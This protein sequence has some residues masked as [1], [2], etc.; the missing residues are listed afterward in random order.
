VLD[1]HQETFPTM[2]AIAR[3][4]IEDLSRRERL[5]WEPNASIEEG[6]QY[7]GIDVQDLPDRPT[8]RGGHAQRGAPVEQ[9]PAGADA[10]L[11]EAASLLEQVLNPGSLD[12]TTLGQP[13]EDRFLFYAIVWERGDDGG[14]VA[15][16]S[17][18]DPTTILRKASSF[19]RYEGT[20]RS[21]T[22]PDFALND[23]ADLIVTKQDI[24][25]LDPR[26]FDYLFA[27]IRALLNDV[28][29][30]L[31]AF[32]ANL[33]NM[34]MSLES[35]E[36]LKQE[37]ER[38]VSFARRLQLLSANPGLT[39]VNPDSLRAALRRHHREPSDFI[40]NGRLEIDRGEVGD[41]LDVC[42]GRWWEADFSNEPRRAGSWSR[43]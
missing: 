33:R 39:R 4:T 8:P 1:L 37:C 43:R 16:V 5:T 18:Y 11:E 3:A 25:I 21:A 32:A 34:P 35:S 36:A 19:F 26:A 41:F 15:F 12:N 42:E 24:A 14:S 23:K 27:D 9:A 30:N 40:R 28:P 22:R 17:N 29:A 20:L 2:R 13:G 7:L 31:I 10:R 38:K 6:E